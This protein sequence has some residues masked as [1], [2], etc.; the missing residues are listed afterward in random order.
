MSSFVL[1][2]GLLQCRA[3]DVGGVGIGGHH[4]MALMAGPCVIESREH[5][6]LMAERVRDIAGKQG[7]P[8]IFKASYDKANRSA[9]SSFRGPGL[10]SGLAILAEVKARFH[11]PVV[12]DVHREEDAWRVAEVCDLLQIPAFLCRQTDFVEAVG[13]A[14]KPVSVKKGQFLAPED[15]ANV[16][17][18]LRS[19]G[20]EDVLLTER[21]VSFGYHQLVSDFR[22]LEIMRQSTGLPVCFDATHSVQQPGGLGTATGGRREFVPLLARAACAVGINALFLEVHD[23]PEEAKSDGPNMVP[24]SELEEL[25]AVCQEIDRGLR[26]R[27]A[28]PG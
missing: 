9:G 18:K 28:S 19:V 27:M 7:I 23:R 2:T 3:F 21:G 10:E 22:S 11:V 4:P 6:L 13:R 14:G 8:V 24:L 17:A 16:A 20:C 1:P 25:L 5:T 12:T 15:M 26:R